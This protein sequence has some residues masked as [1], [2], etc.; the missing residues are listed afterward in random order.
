MKKLICISLIMILALTLLAGCGKNSNPT[1]LTPVFANGVSPNYSGSATSP[2]DSADGDQG[3]IQPP[4]QDDTS[5]PEGYA[6]YNDAHVSFIHPESLKEIIKLY[7]ND[8]ESGASIGVSEQALDASSANF[9]FNAYEVT[10]ENYAETYATIL[11]DL[12]LYS[13]VTVAK[14]Y[15]NDCEITVVKYFEKTESE[16]VEGEETETSTDPRA[17]TADIYVEK[18]ADPAFKEIFIKVSATEYPAGLLPD[19]GV[20][21]SDIVSKLVSSLTVIG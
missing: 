20:S 2:D 7:L 9:G 6:L 19:G 16:S 1:P 5:I 4:S 14:S 12:E 15:A 11:G 18:S 17:G 13:D 8:A 10:Q 21:F 3:D